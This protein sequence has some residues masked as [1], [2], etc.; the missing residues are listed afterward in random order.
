VERRGVE[1]KLAAVL[2][3]DVAGYSRLMGADEEGTL[4]ALKAHRRALV[5]PKIKEHRGEIIKTTG[6]GML[7]EFASVVDAVRC[8]VEI[9]RGMAERNAGVPQTKRIEYRIGINLGD[10]IHDQKDIFGDGVNIAARLEG[11]AEP[12][13][14]C[15]S[16]G[17]RDPV[18]ERLGFTFEDMGEQA[19]KNIAAPVHAY[20]VRF[21]G[22]DPKGPAMAGPTRRRNLVLTAAAG[23]AAIVAIGALAGAMWW[24]RPPSPAPP[25]PS[26]AERAP[27]PLP[28][29]PSVA[30]L[31]F[32]SI[33]GDARQERLAD[34]ITEDV[35]T[36]LSRDRNLF[37]IARNSVFTYKGKV[38]DVRA[39]G[40]ELGVR[41][42]LEGSI[43]TSGDR[44][45]VSAQLIEAATNGH[46]WSDRYDRPLDDVFKVQDEVTQRIAATLAGAWGT[47]VEA[48]AASARR[49]PPAN[50][51]AYDYYALGAEL[52]PRL[53]END[54]AK[55]EA[56]F[57]KAIE[58]DPQFAR[59]YVGLG[60]IYFSQAMHQWGHKDPQVLFQAGKE[61][62]L[63]AISLDPSDPW[64]HAELGQILLAQS[65]IDHGI[66]ELEQ[67]FRLNPNDPSILSAY[68]GWNYVVGRA[69]E[70]VEL[71]NRASRLSPNTPDVYLGYVDPFYATGRYE[72]VIAR[73]KITAHAT[74]NQ[75]LLAAS[76]AQLGR[77]AEAA[78]AVAEL[79]RLYP[80]PSMERLFSDFG[81]IKDQATLAHYMEGARK[82][83]LNECAT[84][85]ELRKYPKMTHLALC[86]ER[87]A[88]N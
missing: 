10:V 29:K 63:Q 18:S 33:G 72:E 1:R 60:R 21:A 49:K 42:V 8:A 35:I 64:A 83:G 9:Q 69:Q 14:I 12:G 87:R 26:A 43:Q 74:W 62:E 6:D 13:G 38:V 23:L 68:G 84:A 46:L 15:I 30:V 22:P 78:A 61:A 5:D 34:G 75:M 79:S 47:V 56:Y 39:V 55:A 24:M 27:L 81:A 71:I 40:R 51:Q 32:N 76:Y 86:D 36:D 50:L 59:A 4:A 7:V 67:A 37:V 48:G 44:V 80:D 19:L 31:P 16:R 20:R 52:V 28:D 88:R 45:R 17:V 41:Y 73:V 82:A 11:L 66:A 2:A 54:R 53:T 3:G 77:Q 65:D 58:H 57:K 85:A 25:P 70:G